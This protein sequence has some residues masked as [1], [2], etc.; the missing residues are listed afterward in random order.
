MTVF[1][2]TSKTELVIFKSRNKVITK[3]RNFRI[4]GQESQGK[5][6]GVLLQSNLHFTTHLVNIKKNIGL[7]SKMRHYVY[8]KEFFANLILFIIQFSFICACEIWVQN[9]NNQLFNPLNANLTKW[10]NTFKQFVGNSRQI[11]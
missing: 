10:S 7:P 8:A 5:Y 3:H 4:A 11:V 1:K 6:L 2:N 9:Q